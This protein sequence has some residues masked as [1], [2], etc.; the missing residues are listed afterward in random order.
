ML[1]YFKCSAAALCIAILPQ[2]SLAQVSLDDLRARSAEANSEMDQL[3][4]ILSASSPDQAMRALQIVMAEGSVEQKRVALEASLASTNQ[5]VRRTG[6]EAFL[7]AK[8][9]IA[10]SF[11]GSALEG[12]HAS[13]F[14]QYILGSGSVDSNRQGRFAFKVGDYSAEKSCWVWDSYVEACMMS[15]TDENVII[16]LARGTLAG[17]GVIGTDGVVRGNVTIPKSS[18]VPYEFVVK[19]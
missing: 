1:S 11:D 8:P 18:T 3:R 13:K 17:I 14:E 6:M 5:A 15:V 2:L 12:Y 10:Y 16:Y 4:E 9:L 19:F 7:N